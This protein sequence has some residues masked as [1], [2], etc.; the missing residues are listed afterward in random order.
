MIAEPM[1]ADMLAGALH[2]AGRF[3]YAASTMVCM[4]TSLAQPGRAALGAQAGEAA[5][6]DVIT[7][8]GFSSV[9]R[10]TET[11]FNIVLGARP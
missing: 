4:P 8:G 7:K 2:D 1:A 3:F 11:P 10:A 5:L 6:S 9:R